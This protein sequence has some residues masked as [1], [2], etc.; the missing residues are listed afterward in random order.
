MRCADEDRVDIRA[1]DQRGPIRFHLG[2]VGGGQRTSAI[3]RW[4][5]HRDQPRAAKIRG[6]LLAHQPGSDNA[7][8]QHYSP[9]KTF[10][11]S[12]SNPNRTSGN[13]ACAIALRKATR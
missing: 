9:T 6:A 10:E 13:P 11:P 5:T 4:V 2:G 8:P 1:F 7:D 3:A 12:W